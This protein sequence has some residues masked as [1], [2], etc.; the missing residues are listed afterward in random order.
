MQPNLGD[1]KMA[2]RYKTIHEQLYSNLFFLQTKLSHIV[3]NKLDHFN[4]FYNAYMIGING[5]NS[6]KEIY[7]LKA[8]D[9]S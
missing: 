5:D 1:Q 4:P 7:S 8:I 3:R 2:I 6:K 9:K